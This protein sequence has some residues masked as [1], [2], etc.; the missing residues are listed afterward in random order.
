MEIELS[1]AGGAVLL[2]MALLLVAGLLGFAVTPYAR[3]GEPLLLSPSNLAMLNYM[4]RSQQ[5]L[6]ELQALDHN[7]AVL[8]DDDTADIYRLGKAAQSSSR[9]AHSVAQSI[10]S[11][12]APAALAGLQV[13]LQEAADNYDRAAQIVLL[14]VGAPSGETRQQAAE[15]MLRAQQSFRKA[16]A[17][18]EVLWATR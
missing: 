14:Y 5:W 2:A 4:R 16:A 6:A 12:E 8:L 10:N 3:S 17:R 18:Q 7:L 11:A 13:A 1:R 15:A 9:H